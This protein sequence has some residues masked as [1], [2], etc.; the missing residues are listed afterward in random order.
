MDLRRQRNS[1]WEQDDDCVRG[2]EDQQ[3]KHVASDFR[4][5][6]KPNYKINKN[7]PEALKGLKSG[8]CPTRSPCRMTITWWAGVTSASVYRLF[9]Y[10]PVALAGISRL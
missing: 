7:P 4:D 10:G 6:K 8:F 3:R 5:P 9:L 1:Q 2:K